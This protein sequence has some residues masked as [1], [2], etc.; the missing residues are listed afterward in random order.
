MDE[1]RALCDHQAPALPPI[2]PNSDMTRMSLVQLGQSF[3][4]FTGLHAHL[5]Q[6]IAEASTKILALEFRLRLHH[7]RMLMGLRSGAKKYTVDAQIRLDP[8]YSRLSED[9][10]VQE[11]RKVAL[12]AAAAG[13]EGKA[14]CLSREISR[15]GTET[16]R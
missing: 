6:Q 13:A 5:V 2:D 4:Y 1:A 12:S 8:E 16:Q 3:Q 10:K 15:R 9:L 7:D 14:A 11:I